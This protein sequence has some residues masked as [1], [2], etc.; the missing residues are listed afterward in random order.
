LQKA[1]AGIR[2]AVARTQPASSERSTHDRSVNPSR[3]THFQR[4]SVG[5]ARRIAARLADRPALR[6]GS[7][8]TLPIGAAVLVLLASLVSFQP[9]SAV[10]GSAGSTD[11]VRIA[12]GGEGQGVVDGQY[13]AKELAGL[14]GRNGGTTGTNVD[15]GALPSSGPIVDDGTLYKPVAVDTTVADAKD[16]LT[17]YVVQSGDTLTGIASHFGV[18]M[19][20]IWWANT[21]TSKDALHVGQTLLVPPVTGL[22]VTVKDGDTLEGLATKY[23]VDPNQVV[24]V[25]RLEDTNLVIGQTLIL[26][27]AAGAPIPTPKPVARSS[28]S[29]G[30]GSSVRS[31]YSGGAFAWPI[32]CAHSYISQYFH[33]GHPAIDIA[34]PYGSTIVA[35]AGGTV[36]FAGWKNNGGG[37]Q[38]YVSHGGN[39]YTGY[40]HMSAITVGVGQGVG[41]GQQL[42]RVGCTGNCTGPHVHFVVSIGPPETGT[43]LNPLRYY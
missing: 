1:L 17:H 37:Y 19:M 40:Y 14:L 26:P 6:L 9:A 38:V 15:E 31:S 32:C 7:E 3:A 11:P 5:V 12:V 30:G 24:A 21:L 28:G 29:G 13:D 2:R 25:N 36:V 35:A 16:L 8:R 41:R 20:T 33:Y 4:R 43:R 39:L 22:V 42:G 23:N 10:S 18:S 34:A 27:D